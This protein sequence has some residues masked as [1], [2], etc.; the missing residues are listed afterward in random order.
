MVVK[1][2]REQALCTALEYYI[3]FV[4]EDVR[5]TT[6]YKNLQ[7]DTLTKVRTRYKLDTMLLG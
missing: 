1:N 2:V 5:K 3:F 6:K 4:L 7:M